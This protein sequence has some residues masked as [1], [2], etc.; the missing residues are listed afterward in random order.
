VCIAGTL[1]GAGR[2]R[3]GWGVMEPHV[4]RW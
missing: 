3:D 4:A 2:L 1:P